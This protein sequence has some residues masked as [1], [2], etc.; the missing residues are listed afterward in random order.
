ME[1]TGQRVQLGPL[2]QMAQPDRPA[3]RELPEQ[4][5]RPKMETLG[6]VT[7]PKVITP[8]SVSRSARA[9]PPPVIKLSI[10]TIRA[11]LIPGPVSTRSRTTPVAARTQ[12]T[13]VLRFL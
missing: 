5:V 7:L 11:A 12:P 13:A 3:Q 9:I 4:L 2:D 6:L 8:F 10:A 1:R